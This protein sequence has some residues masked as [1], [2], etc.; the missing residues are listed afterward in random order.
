MSEENR[1]K[2][3]VPVRW[4]TLGEAVAIAAVAISGLGLYNSWSNREAT[5]PP[6]PAVV[7]RATP[8]VLRVTV[9]EQGE[10]LTLAP[11]ADSHV[12]QSQ[13]I[14]FPSALKV[15]PVE[16]TGDPRIEADWFARPLRRVMAD[17]PDMTGDRKLPVLIVTRY[18]EDGA[19]RTETAA[20]QLG[21]VIEEGGIFGGG[22]VRL[23]GLSLLDRGVRNGQQRLDV[24]WRP[25]RR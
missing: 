10:R 17:A 15:S 3:R 8:L 6:P 12:I 19:E 22:R 9:A 21:Y 14:T 18:L 23:H 24:M 13:T 1:P 11:V 5:T 16:T 7:E 2:R 20:Y 25:A 4:V